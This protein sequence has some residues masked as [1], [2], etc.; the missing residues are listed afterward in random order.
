M[1]PSTQRRRVTEM[2]EAEFEAWLDELGDNIERRM[3]EELRPQT[4]FLVG[5]ICV[6]VPILAIVVRL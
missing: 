3:R 6:W 1:E 4:R 5:V 2:T